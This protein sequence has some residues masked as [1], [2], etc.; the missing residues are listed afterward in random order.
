MSERLNSKARS[1]AIQRTARALLIEQQIDVNEQVVI[2][3]L[4]KLLVDRELCHLTTA[5]IHI[6]T[7]IR[8]ARGQIS[9]ERQWGGTRPGA[10]RPKE[11]AAP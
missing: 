7:A 2:L 11:E 6:A 4:A 10:G 8:R 1:E 5:K 3:P 9:K